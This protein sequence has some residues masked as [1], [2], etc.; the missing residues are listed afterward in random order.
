[1]LEQTG[2]MRQHSGPYFQDWRRKVAQSVGAV[3]LDDLRR[4]E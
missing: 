2:E 4:D 1:M 3:V